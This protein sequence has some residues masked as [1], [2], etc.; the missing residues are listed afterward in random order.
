MWFAAS[1]I[2]AVVYSARG[3][4][5]KLYINKVDK[6]VLALA[7]RLFAL[8]LFLIPLIINPSLIV[9]FQDLPLRFWLATVYVSAISTPI[10]MIFFYK[11]LQGAEISYLVPILSFSPIITSI[12]GYIFFKETP[13]ILGLLGML[14]IVSGIYILN[15]TKVG[16]GI[17][18]PLKHLS[19]N[20]S[21]RYLSIMLAF[22]SIAIVIDK[23]AITGANMYFYAFVNYLLVTI[24][25]FCIT[26]YKAKSKLI[27][28]RTN[29]KPFAFIGLIVA[30][31]TLLRFYALQHGTSSYV[32]AIMASSTIFTTIF[33]IIF[34]K[35]QN[36]YVKIAVACIATIGIIL[37]KMAK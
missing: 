21:V 1:L 2:S 20:K 4:V 24:S 6:Y 12:F 28:L 30:V 31:Y 13:T 19:G 34:L 23:V 5:E 27:E 22:Y 32:S 35:E 14:L 11:A 25:L 15:V 36:K 33:G 9:N 29:F 3:I 37:L 26:L 7:V 10:E 17:F 8:P 18:E 16:E